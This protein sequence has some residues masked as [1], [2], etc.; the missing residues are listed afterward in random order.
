MCNK[1]FRE[2]GLFEGD[3]FTVRVS[4]EGVLDWMTSVVESGPVV[5]D[6]RLN[7][8]IGSY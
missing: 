1:D 4:N 3:V 8:I 2:M 5:T 7:D 6:R